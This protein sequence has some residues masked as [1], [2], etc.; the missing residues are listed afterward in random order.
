MSE[1]KDKKIKCFDLQNMNEDILNKIKIK[2][3]TDKDSIN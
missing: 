3:N 2:I 1:E